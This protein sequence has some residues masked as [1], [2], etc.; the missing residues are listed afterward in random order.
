MKKPMKSGSESKKM[1]STKKKMAKPV[2]SKKPA[3]KM[4]GS[5]KAC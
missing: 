2:P 5:K 3:M 4:G 1:D